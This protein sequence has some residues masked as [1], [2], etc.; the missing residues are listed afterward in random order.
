MSR[1]SKIQQPTDSLNLSRFKHF[2]KIHPEVYLMLKDTALAIKKK[3]P[4]SR[5]SFVV[6]KAK[7]KFKRSFS[8][9]NTYRAFYAR[10]LMETV[11]ELKGFFNLRAQSSSKGELLRVAAKNKRKLHGNFRRNQK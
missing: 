6:E 3:V 10:H 1:S 11:P 2:H 4:K 9:D 8:L 5:I 7:E